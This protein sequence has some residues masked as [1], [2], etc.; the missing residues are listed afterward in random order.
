MSNDKILQIIPAPANMFARHA[1][2]YEGEPYESFSP[3]VCLALVDAGNYRY[4]EPMILMEGEASIDEASSFSDFD[5]IV[6]KEDT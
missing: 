6:F 4:V 3:I 5:G 2:E 1:G